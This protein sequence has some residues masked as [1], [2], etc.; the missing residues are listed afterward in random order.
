MSILTPMT[1]VDTDKLTKQMKKQHAASPKTDPRTAEDLRI[2]LRALTDRMQY[3]EELRDNGKA[4][5]KELNER[6]AKLNNALATAKD[7]VA[8]RPRLRSD[9]KELEYALPA[10]TEEIADVEAYVQRHTNIANGVAL[11]IKG[12][13]HKRLKELEAQEKILSA[14]GL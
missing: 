3:H 5:V 7:M 14:A 4:K 10:L 1:P 11:L 2:E 6:Y 9:I 8:I 13:D 12:F